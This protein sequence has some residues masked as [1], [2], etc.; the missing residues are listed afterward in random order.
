MTRNSAWPVPSAPLPIFELSQCSAR[1]R[2][3]FRQNCCPLPVDERRGGSRHF[4]IQACIGVI[5]VAF[6]PLV[7]NGI[8]L[9][10]L[11]AGR[12]SIAIDFPEHLTT[13]REFFAICPFFPLGNR[14]KL[15]SRSSEIHS[16][17]RHG[18]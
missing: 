15:E 11:Q 12:F 5:R 13:V 17:N 4:R 7:D 3:R 16:I 1:C 2:S 10:F 18:W 6:A 8:T 14:V 9:Q